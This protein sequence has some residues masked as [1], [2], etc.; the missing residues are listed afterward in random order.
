LQV[1]LLLG[2][3]AFRENVVIVREKIE[4]LRE[5]ERIFCDRGRLFRTLVDL[6]MKFGLSGTSAK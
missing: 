3:A 6:A 1:K 2:R 4:G 5:L